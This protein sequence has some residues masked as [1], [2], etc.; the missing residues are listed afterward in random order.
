MISITLGQGA[1][2]F[3]TADNQMGIRKLN[4]GHVEQE[5]MLGHAS[6]RNLDNLLT[7]IGSLRIHTERN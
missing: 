5:I 2:F 1:E 3:I 4:H 7:H 6:E